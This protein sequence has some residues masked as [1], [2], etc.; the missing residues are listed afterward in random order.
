M[1]QAQGQPEAQEQTSKQCPDAHDP[2]PLRTDLTARR[3]IKLSFQHRAEEMR[4]Q[5][6]ESEQGR[7]SNSSPLF[8]A[9]WIFWYFNTQNM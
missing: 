5:S 1:I 3:T 4:T 9:D 6:G 7:G 2:A 8:G